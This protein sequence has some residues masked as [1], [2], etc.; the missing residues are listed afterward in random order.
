LTVNFSYFALLQLSTVNLYFVESI[1]E[2]SCYLCSINAVRLP[3][4]ATVE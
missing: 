1:K 4:V 3:R 2:R